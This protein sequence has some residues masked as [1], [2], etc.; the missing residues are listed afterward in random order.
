LDFL[1]TSRASY[2]ALSEFV[3]G[4]TIIPPTSIQDAE[5]QVTQLVLR[6]LSLDMTKNQLAER[7]VG[8]S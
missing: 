7:L 5:R 1:Y 8:E 6:L 2:L 4:I 3:G